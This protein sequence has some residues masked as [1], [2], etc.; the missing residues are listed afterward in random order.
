MKKTLTSCPFC[1]SSPKIQEYKPHGRFYEVCCPQCGEFD[2]EESF[3]EDGILGE[4]FGPVGS[5][6]R[7]NASRVLSRNPENATNLR[8]PKHLARLAAEANEV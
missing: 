7:T 4:Y 2:I 6:L 5:S 1:E 3:I 8:K